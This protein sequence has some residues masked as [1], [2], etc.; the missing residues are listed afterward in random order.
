[1]SKERFE[2]RPDIYKPNVY[3]TAK[4]EYL[5]PEECADILNELAAEVEILRAIERDYI[6]TS[7]GKKRVDLLRDVI[8]R[9]KEDKG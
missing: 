8:N 7:T 2:Y 5:D 4:E 3:D 1:M 9:E 6:L